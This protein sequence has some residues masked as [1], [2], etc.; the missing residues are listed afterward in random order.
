MS[1]ILKTIAAVFF[2]AVMLSS[3]EDVIELPARDGKDLLIVEGWLSNKQ[4]PQYVKLYLAR[5]INSNGG[6]TPV[7][8]AN[9]TL[10]SDAGFSAK[11]S[12]VE[13]GKYL[14][15]RVQIA[16]GVTYHLDINSEYGDY[17]ASST[18][19]RMPLKVDSLKF[20]Y[21]EKSIVYSESGYYPYISG[22]ESPGKGD[23]MML[24]IYRNGKFLTRARDLNLLEDRFIDGNYLQNAELEIDSPFV[25]NDRIRVE[26]WS[27]DEPAFDFWSDIR[28][29]LLNGG[30]FATPL[31]NTRSNVKRKA[32]GAIEVNGFFGVSLVSAIEKVIQAPDN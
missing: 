18:A 20:Q 28:Q 31:F 13:P 21:N 4:G 27:L 30:V 17:E 1:T 12:E 8:G 32:D 24:K 29:Q 11:V 16:I 5:P 6:Y 19:S 3:C 22:T 25:A 2:A 23:F 9:I 15:P 14:L 26:V 10:R 7:T